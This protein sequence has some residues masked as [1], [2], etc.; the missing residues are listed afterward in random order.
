MR[1]IEL[2]GPV[3]S[4]FMYALLATITAGL[5]LNH[6]GSLHAQQ[7]SEGQPHK[8]EAA[9]NKSMYDFVADGFEL[10]SVTYDTSVLGPQS[11]SPDVH[12]FLQKGADLVRCDFRKRDQTSY[13][14]CYRLARIK[15]P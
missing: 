10:K 14:W 12:Y 11:D 5:L 2:E 9:T 8:W 4:R 13:Y 7:L 15:Q 3:T 6:G 1:S